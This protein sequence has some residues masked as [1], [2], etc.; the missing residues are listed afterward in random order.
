MEYF[1]ERSK[2]STDG[3]SLFFLTKVDSIAV[4]PTSEWIK[5]YRF[6]GRAIPDRLRG[7]GLICVFVVL[8]LTGFLPKLRKYDV[9]TDRFAMKQRRIRESRN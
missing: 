7:S 6:H 3:A 9:E 4:T 1:Q 2:P 5:I 8:F